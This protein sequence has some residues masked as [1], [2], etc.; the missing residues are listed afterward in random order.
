MEESKQEEPVII[1]LHNGCTM[2][3]T[4]TFILLSGCDKG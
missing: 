2:S 4:I 1:V 3:L